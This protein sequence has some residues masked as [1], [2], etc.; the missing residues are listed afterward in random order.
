MFKRMFATLL[1]LLLTLPLAS[2]TNVHAVSSSAPSSSQQESCETCPV[3][4]PRLPEGIELI[5]TFDKAGRVDTI[6]IV[7]KKGGGRLIYV[8]K[9]RCQIKQLSTLI[10]F[11]TMS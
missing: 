5:K 3:D 4:S 9:L 2:F 10:L 7:P 1:F 8:V 6:T 11:K